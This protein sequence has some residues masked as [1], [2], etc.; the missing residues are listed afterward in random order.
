ARAPV[1]VPRPDLGEDVVGVVVPVTRAPDGS[2]PAGARG[3]GLSA[4]A[5]PY[6][7]WANRGAEAMRV[8][9]PR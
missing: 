6:F 7:A 5:V 3:D 1:A 9:I 8:W 2:A 4:G